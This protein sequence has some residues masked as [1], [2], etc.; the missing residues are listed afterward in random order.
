M[1]QKRII[2]AVYDD[3]FHEYRG[4]KTALSFQ[5]SDYDVKVLGM[6]LSDKTLT[7]WDDIPNERLRLVRNFP[8]S[9]NMMIFWLK[10]FFKLLNTKADI[11]YSHDIFPL[12][13][14]FMASKLK[15]IPFV[16]DA[17]EFW[18]GNSQLENRPFMKKFWTFYERIFISGAKRVIT[19]SEPIAKEL[20]RIYRI[21]KVGVFTNLPLKKEL[22]SDRNKLRDLLSIGS[23]KKIVLYQGRFLFNNGLDTVIRSFKDVT[24]NAVLVLIGEGS[25]KDYL[26][27]TAEKSGISGRVFFAGPFPHGELIKYTVC[28]DIGLCLIKNSGKSYYY[29]T[30][31]K[32]F[33]FI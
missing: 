15:R 22:P 6:R 30:P 12:F 21:D 27:D 23:E 14:V 31:N 29:S 17:H 18:H 2:F 13:P 28:A 10:L 9:L 3:L 33:E 1:K 20:E 5:R 19:V 11:L 26:A 7:G 24:D 8:L 25:E 4:Y 16:Y 32:M